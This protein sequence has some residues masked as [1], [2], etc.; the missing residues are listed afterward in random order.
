VKSR[1]EFAMIIT[2]PKM[3]PVTAKIN[4]N[5]GS[6]ITDKK[7]SLFGSEVSVWVDIA[8]EQVQF[9]NC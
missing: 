8:A 4:Q 7:K 5:M 9:G 2:V 6:S 3:N 1:N